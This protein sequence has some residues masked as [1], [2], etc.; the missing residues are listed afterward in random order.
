MWGGIAVLT[1][2]IIVA[3]TTVLLWGETIYALAAG[4]GSALLPSGGLPLGNPGELVNLISE[5]VLAMAEI[6]GVSPNIATAAAA[7][8]GGIV[9]ISRYRS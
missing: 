7:G 4:V 9:L 1:V 8:A 2:S 6:A 5:L 3:R